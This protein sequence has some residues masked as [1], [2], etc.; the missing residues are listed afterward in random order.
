MQISA[1]SFINASSFDRFRIQT[2]PGSNDRSGEVAPL[3]AVAPVDKVKDQSEELQ[4]QR[5]V[6]AL[7]DR[8]REVR[9]HEQAHLSAAGGIALSGA[10]FQYV[11]GPDGQR[12][13]TGGDVSIDTSEV[14]GDPAATMRKAETIRR[15]AMAPAKPSAQDYS[16]AANAAAMANKAAVEFL[17]GPQDSNR[18]GSQLDVNA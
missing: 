15:A 12:Y 11:T 9:S 10:R 3:E 5:E 2:N 18:K 14:P 4:Q 7:K 8:D 1:S 17:R 16:V 13:A 6:Q